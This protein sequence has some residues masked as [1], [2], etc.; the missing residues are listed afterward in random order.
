M[1]RSAG[2]RGVDLLKTLGVN[3]KQPKRFFRAS[4]P[5]CLHLSTRPKFCPSSSCSLIDLRHRGHNGAFL[6]CGAGCQRPNRRNERPASGFSG[7]HK[8]IGS[9]CHSTSWR[10]QCF[11]RQRA[12]CTDRKYASM[13]AICCSL[14]MPQK[15]ILVPGTVSP[16]ALMKAMR[17]F[18]FHTRPDFFMASE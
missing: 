4:T 3:K 11:D 7:R 2:F 9:P 17:F 10:T 1:S 8:S 15:R 6:S 12:Y 18:S 13:S 14:L 16:G 5:S